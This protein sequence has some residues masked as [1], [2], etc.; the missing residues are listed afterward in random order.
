MSFA[1]EMQELAI[2]FLTEDFADLAKPMTL[3]VIGGSSE[4][5]TGIPIKESFKLDS[6]RYEEGKVYKIFTTPNQ[7]SIDPDA[8]NVQ[9]LFNGQVLD[10][11]EVDKDAANA[12]YFI[13]GKVEKTKPIEIY[14]T[15]EAEDGQGGFTDTWSLLLSTNAVVSFQK[16][17]ESF[18]ENEGIKT[19]QKVRAVFRYFSGITEKMKL[20]YNGEEMTIISVVNIDEQD[21]WIEIIAERINEPL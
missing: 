5:G 7:W 15:T 9:C 12:A 1:E 14:S 8:G 19:Q 3:S 17:A 16:A 2:E 18:N 4:S 11:L 13:T 10:V 20:K 6:K 21:Q